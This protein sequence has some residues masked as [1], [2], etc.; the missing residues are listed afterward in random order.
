MITCN[1]LGVS[2]E[3]ERN[4]TISEVANILSVHVDTIRM[5]DAQGKITPIRVGNGW[6][7]FPQSEIDRILQLDNYIKPRC[8][9][10]KMGNLSMILASGN[11]FVC[12]ECGKTYFLTCGESKKDLFFE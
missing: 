10:C 4:Y 8:P 3:T 12:L 2:M 7:R 1:N 9:I 11:G 5:W 6:R